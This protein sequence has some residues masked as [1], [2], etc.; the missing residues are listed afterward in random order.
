MILSDPLRV[1]GLGFD[2]MT[3]AALSFPRQ[4]LLGSLDVVGRYHLLECIV[5]LV[6]AHSLCLPLLNCILRALVW[7]RFLIKYINIRDS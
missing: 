5:C 2:F 3:S 1:G 7:Q 6:E 4:L